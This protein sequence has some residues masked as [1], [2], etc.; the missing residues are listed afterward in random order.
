MT[1]RRNDGFGL[2][3]W[4]AAA[5]TLLLGSAPGWAADFQSPR[6]AALGGAGHAAPM[7]NDAIYLNPSF[8]SFMPSYRRKPAG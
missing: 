5:F 7:L 8:V 3:A 4:I 1:N 6:T 2:L